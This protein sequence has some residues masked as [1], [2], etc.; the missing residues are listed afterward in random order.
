M[1]ESLREITVWDWGRSEETIFC[2][3][4]QRTDYE[5]C[6]DLFQ[7]GLPLL[8]RPFGSHSRIGFCTLSPVVLFKQFI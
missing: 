7:Q 5:A 4:N 6:S 8:R 3:L 1:F 2:S